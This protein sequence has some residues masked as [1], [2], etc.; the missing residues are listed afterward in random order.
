M[1]IDIEKARKLLP[2][3]YGQVSDGDIQCM[4]DY[5][6]FICDFSIR[7][8]EEHPG[9]S[10][11]D[12]KKIEFGKPKI[13]KEWHQ[14]NKMPIKATLDQKIKWHID[15]VAHCKCRPMPDT[16]KKEIQKRLG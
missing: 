7:W 14:D 4:L 10:F 13:N 2:P 3:E 8:H 16:I 6:Y 12:R 9:E 5:M 15:H 11:S 1:I